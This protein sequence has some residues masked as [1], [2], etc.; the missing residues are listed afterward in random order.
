MI[1]ETDEISAALADAAVRWPGCTPT[2]L[3]RLLVAEGH[4]ALRGSV[5]ADRA[6][7]AETS[8]ILTGV[9]Q[10]GYLAELRGEWPG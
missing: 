3:L 1:T 2:E 4:A 7:V 8:G 5:R 6:A 10:P 9:Y